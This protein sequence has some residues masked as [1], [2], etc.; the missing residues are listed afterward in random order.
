MTVTTD[1]GSDT[2]VGVAKP[3]VRF[4]Y[5]R[6]SGAGERSDRVPVITLTPVFAGIE[7][8]IDVPEQ[9]RW[10]LPRPIFCVGRI[11]GIA[12]KT[13]HLEFI[14]NRVAKAERERFGVKA[15]RQ[16]LRDAVE[17]CFNTNFGFSYPPINIIIG[18]TVL[19]F[20][21]CRRNA[22]R[23][24]S[25]PGRHFSICRPPPFDILEIGAVPFLKVRNDVG[26]AQ[27]FAS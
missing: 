10:P 18:K 23:H 9:F 22:E 20:I 17:Q 6:D 3:R 5:F 2:V 14:D 11:G 19:S 1:L 27:N 16:I 12:A 24:L 7:C 21:W 15:P 4:D 13:E 26:E 8:Q 25:Y